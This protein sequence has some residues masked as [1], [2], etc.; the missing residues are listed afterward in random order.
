MIQCFRQPFLMA[1]NVEH[2]QYRA[3]NRQDCY[4]IIKQIQTGIWCRITIRYPLS[5]SSYNRSTKTNLG[6]FTISRDHT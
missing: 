6:C 4:A 5:T 2:P 3:V 1:M